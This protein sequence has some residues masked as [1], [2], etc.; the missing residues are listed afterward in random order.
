M[1][2]TFPIYFS[3]YE[4]I[5]LIIF[6]FFNRIAKPC[7]SGSESLFW[8]TVSWDTAQDGVKVCEQLCE[9]AEFSKQKINADFQMNFSSSRFIKSETLGHGF[10]SSVQAHWK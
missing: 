5:S 6:Q 3:I 4:Y 9:V 10:P 7:N 8:F 2:Y 1:I